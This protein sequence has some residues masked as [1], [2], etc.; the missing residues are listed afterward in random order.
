MEAGSKSGL[1]PVPASQYCSRRATKL[2]RIADK[3]GV[4]LK[5]YIYDFRHTFAARFAE[6]TRDLVALAAILGHSTLK[7]VMRYVHPSAEQQR[8]AMEL[9]QQAAADAPADAAPQP[10]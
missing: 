9:Y 5:W 6:R 3:T 1:F 7:M 4:A 2:A 10:S 8:R